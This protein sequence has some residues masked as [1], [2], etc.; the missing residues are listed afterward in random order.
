MNDKR[1]PYYT[2]ALYGAVGVQ[3]AASVVAGL[4]FGNYL[5]KKLH[6]SPWLAL[7]GTILGTAGGFWNLVR[8]LKWNEGHKGQ[9][10][11]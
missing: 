5:D 11:V 1:T 7:A 10:P 2:F 3:L 8:I 6:T 4:V 9:N